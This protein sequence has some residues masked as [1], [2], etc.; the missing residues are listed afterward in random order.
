VFIPRGPGEI[1]PPTPRSQSPFTNNLEQ[2]DHPNM[3]ILASA[4]SSATR[5]LILGPDSSF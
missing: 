4:V 5:A 2:L 1:L 3:G